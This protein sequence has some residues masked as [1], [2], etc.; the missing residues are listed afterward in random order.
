MDLPTELR[1]II[2]EF[3][4]TYDGGLEWFWTTP[5]N[6]TRLGRLKSVSS[7]YPITWGTQLNSLC[8]SRQLR[9]ETDGMLLEVNAVHFEKS[10]MDN[11]QVDRYSNAFDEITGDITLFLSRVEEGSVGKM[12]ISMTIHR[13][14]ELMEDKE[15]LEL[16]VIDRSWNLSAPSRLSA[17]AFLGQ[18]SRL[19]AMLGHPSFAGLN[20]TWRLLS[21]CDEHFLEVFKFHLSEPDYQVALSYIQNGI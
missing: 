2:A 8:L 12:S 17:L 9:Q 18:G 20:K 13:V 3:A 14:R 1:I 19:K 11:Y 21:G 6:G 10:V 4:L 15:Y 16:Q 7:S 5:P